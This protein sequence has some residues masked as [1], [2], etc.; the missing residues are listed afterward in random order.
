MV[1][2]AK[3]LAARDNRNSK[4]MQA[5]DHNSHTPLDEIGVQPLPSVL[6][7]SIAEQERRAIEQ[8]SINRRSLRIQQALAIC[9]FVTVN[10]YGVQAWLMRETLK[11][12]IHTAQV[13]D[14]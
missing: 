1:D 4:E 14:E 10:I 5:A 2:D 6:E 3:T 7:S 8:R 12:A 13:A 9:G 11:D